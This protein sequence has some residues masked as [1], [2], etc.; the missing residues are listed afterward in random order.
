MISQITGTVQYVSENALTV[1]VGGLSY[2]I[3]IP[4]SVLRNL[5]GKLDKDAEIAEKVADRLVKELHQKNI[6]D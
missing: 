3:F 1:N 5:Q 6:P 4:T 2:E